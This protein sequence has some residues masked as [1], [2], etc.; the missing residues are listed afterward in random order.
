MLVQYEYQLE[1]TTDRT[2]SYFE[3]INNR[4]ICPYMYVET[5][6]TL[7]LLRPHT[8]LLS[9]YAGLTEQHRTSERSKLRA[10]LTHKV[11]VTFA[12]R[13]KLIFI[14]HQTKCKTIVK[15]CKRNFKK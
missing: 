2:T 11:N 3:A 5:F 6:E 12:A 14:P 9:T 13:F 7:A 4:M 15:M 1:K 8:H 10:A